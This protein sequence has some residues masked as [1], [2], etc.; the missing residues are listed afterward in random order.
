LCYVEKYESWAIKSIISDGQELNLHDLTPK[1][2]VLALGFHLFT[3][4]LNSQCT[5]ALRTSKQANPS[6]MEESLA[7]IKFLEQQTNTANHHLYRCAGDRS[8][9][10]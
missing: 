6:Y 2:S 7:V 10:C 5:N 9:D 4:S 3:R 8:S 1:A